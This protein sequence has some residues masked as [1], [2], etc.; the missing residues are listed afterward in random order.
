MQVMH[1][2][3]EEQQATNDPKLM[4]TGSIFPQK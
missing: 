2:H 3:M 1:E 4:A